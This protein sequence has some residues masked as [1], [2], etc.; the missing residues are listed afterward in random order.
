MALI[1]E[2][3]Y[4][5]SWLG[6]VP[7]NIKGKA[8]NFK[9]DIPSYKLSQPYS[10]KE[11]DIIEGVILK[12]EGTD[13][14]EYSDLRNKAIEFVLY[15]LLLVDYL[16]ISKEIWEALFRERGLVQSFYISVKLEKA[17][18]TDGTETELYTVMDLEA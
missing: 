16:F 13:G 14:K 17:K 15:P 1:V 11:G 3:K 9:L 6:G 2:S 4:T 10:L 12:V 5:S 8:S 18:K 7:Y